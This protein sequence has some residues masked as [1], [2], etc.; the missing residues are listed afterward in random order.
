M[1]TASAQRGYNT[2]ASG[3]QGM[4]VG[5]RL[6][7]LE[8]AIASLQQTLLTSDR[9][10]TSQATAT[11]DSSAGYRTEE[12]FAAP[13]VHPRRRPT[14][15]GAMRWLFHEIIP[16]LRGMV[17]MFFDPRYELGVPVR[18]STLVLLCMVVTSTWWVPFSSLPVFG[19]ILDRGMMLVSGYLLFKL[20]SSESRKYRQTAPA[21]PETLRWNERR[22][23]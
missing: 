6:D 5:R 1:E 9:V 17:S 12:D 10:R 7:R 15:F 4:E 11:E 16:E 21:L 19:F 2:P 14:M 23:R 22:E 20:L 8:N 3:S 18:V 13:S